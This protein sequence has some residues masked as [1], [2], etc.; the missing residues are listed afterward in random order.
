MN[1]AVWLLDIVKMPKWKYHSTK[2]CAVLHCIEFA[3]CLSAGRLKLSVQYNSHLACSPFFFFFT[4]WTLSVR[5]FCYFVAYF[6]YDFSICYSF[7]NECVCVLSFVCFVCNR[8]MDCIICERVFSQL[9]LLLFF[10]SFP[11][12]RQEY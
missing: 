3:M 10:F 4:Y 8:K 1:F 9:L 12:L 7:R 5:S 2:Y 11:C 6:R